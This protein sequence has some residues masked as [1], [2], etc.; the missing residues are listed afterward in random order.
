MEEHDLKVL[1]YT[2]ENNNGK[3][4]FS[5]KKCN[6]LCNNCAFDYMMEIDAKKKAGNYIPDYSRNPVK[7]GT[8]EGCDYEAAILAR[9]GMYDF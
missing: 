2:R 3:C 4:L 1:N 9:Q 8:T 5:A 7:H 6:G